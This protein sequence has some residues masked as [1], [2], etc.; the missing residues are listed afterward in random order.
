MA[1]SMTNLSRRVCLSLLSN[2]KLLN[3][4]LAPP[5]FPPL[6]KL[7]TPTLIHFPTHLAL[8]SAKDSPQSRLYD[9]PMQFGWTGGIRNNRR[10]HENEEPEE[11]ANRCAIQWHRVCVYQEGLG[12]LVM[13]HALPGEIWRHIFADSITGLVRLLREVSIRRNEFRNVSNGRWIWDIH[14]RR[15]LMNSETDQWIELMLLLDTFQPGLETEDC[16]TWKGKGGR[17]FRFEPFTSK[18]GMNKPK[19]CSPPTGFFKMNVDGAVNFDWR[20]SGIGVVLRDAENNRDK[21]SLILESDSSTALKW[22]NNPQ[23]C[24]V[25]YVDLVR[26]IQKTVLQF[27]V[28]TTLVKRCTNDEADGIAKSGIG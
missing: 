20:C 7:P 28:I 24:P 6:L 9:R 5:P 8:E 2:P 27:N 13:K 3:F 17:V 12:G 21:G 11:Y 25:R 19:W 22:I 18:L 23:T 10:P 14:L 1:N 15:N 16:F 26:V 4:P